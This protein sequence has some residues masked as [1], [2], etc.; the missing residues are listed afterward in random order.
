MAAGW[1]SILSLN[2]QI[3]LKINVNVFKI[4][5][6]IYEQTSKLQNIDRNKNVKFGVATSVDEPR[7]GL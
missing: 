7:F 1:I 6:I 4:S 3:L 5:Q 2:L